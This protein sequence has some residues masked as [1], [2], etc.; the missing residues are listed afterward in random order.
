MAKD[1]RTE[2]RACPR[3]SPKAEELI[4]HGAGRSEFS[5][6]YGATTNE[7]E[8]LTLI[9]EN[10]ARLDA[11]ASELRVGHRHL[12]NIVEIDPPIQD[13]LSAEVR[14]QNPG[15]IDVERLAGKYITH[16]GYVS[17]LPSTREAEQAEVAGEELLH[18]GLFEV[19]L[20]SD[21]PVQPAQQR[22]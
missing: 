11:D 7:L 6:V 8:G 10:I 4:L 16:L 9:E 1:V 13:V 5:A 22:I 14:T 3:V 15:S 20:L 2:L 17:A 21:K 18:G 12:E 19:A